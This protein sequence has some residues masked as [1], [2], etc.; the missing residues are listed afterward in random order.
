MR[1]RHL[2]AGL[3]VPIP[4]HDARITGADFFDGKR[5]RTIEGAAQRNDEGEIIAL[6]SVQ[7]AFLDRF[8]FQ[9]GY[10]TPGFVNAAIVLIE[11]LKRT[12]VPRAEL[13]ATITEAL[14]NHICRCTTRRS[15]M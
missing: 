2:L 8:S 13:E 15:A 12:P 1:G 4:D 5:I 3:I 10:C 11:R 7:Q 6:S 14:E 9:C